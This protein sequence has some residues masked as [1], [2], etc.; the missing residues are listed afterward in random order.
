MYFT[1]SSLTILVNTKPVMKA[2]VTAFSLHSNVLHASSLH[3]IV[4]HSFSPYTVT[5]C[6]NVLHSFLLRY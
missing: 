1:A 2:E 6:S 3:T 4:L 5:F